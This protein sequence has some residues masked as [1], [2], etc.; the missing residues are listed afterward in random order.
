M[1]NEPSIEQILHD[2]NQK[3]ESID[4]IRSRVRDPSFP[5]A[6]LLLLAAASRSRELVSAFDFCSR[7]RLLGIS[8]AIGRMQLDSV[9]RIHATSIVDDADDF[10]KFILSGQEPRK[11]KL[12]E[13]SPKL[14]GRTNQSEKLLTDKFLCTDLS[15]KWGP[16]LRQ[17]NS[18]D[19]S[20]LRGHSDTDGLLSN[21]FGFVYRDGNMAVHLSHFHIMEL[22]MNDNLGEGKSP[23]FK[24]V[25]CAGD[26]VRIQAICV[27]MLFLVD[28]LLQLLTE[29][30]PEQVI[31]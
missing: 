6:K 23:N 11:Y 15:E 30:F 12:S 13:R 3:Q 14:F 9:L 16:E 24:P 28:Q 7:G 19:P 20:L 29:N 5:P 21:F 4:A 27:E 31:E 8:L 1:D 22:F 10:V 2:I 25:G 18:D 26:E 17:L